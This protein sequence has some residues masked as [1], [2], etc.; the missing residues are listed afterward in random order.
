[1][2]WLSSAY[3]AANPA[4]PDILRKNAQSPYTNAAVYQTLRDLIAVGSFTANDSALASAPSF[5]RLSQPGGAQMVVSPAQRW[6][7][8]QDAVHKN[9]CFIG[10]N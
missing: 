3:E 1:M 6:V 7:N 8:F 5:L 4:V 9:P 10:A 2:V